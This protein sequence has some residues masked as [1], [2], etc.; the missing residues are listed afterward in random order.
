VPIDTTYSDWLDHRAASGDSRSCQECHMPPVPEAGQ[1]ARFQLPRGALDFHE[2]SFAFTET[3]PEEGGV[4]ANVESRVD[5][6]R[7]LVRVTIENRAGHPIPAGKAGRTLLLVV[8]A[9]LPGGEI[10]PAARGP[11]LGADAG[12]PPDDD[13]PFDDRLLSGALAGMP[14]TTFARRLDS[15]GPGAPYLTATRVVRDDRIAAGDRVPV[16]FEFVLP[17]ESGEVRLRVA[18]LSRQIPWSEW[19]REA[20]PDEDPPDRILVEENLRIDR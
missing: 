14:G 19:V 20:G 16:D 6:D 12:L 10:L 7:A 1:I 15:T 8:A 11:V 18:I 3:R 2:H 4:S 17:P 13:L 5:G 9:T